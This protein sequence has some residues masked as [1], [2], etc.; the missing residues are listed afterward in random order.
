L[1]WG[2]AAAA[3]NAALWPVAARAATA[4]T[5][6]QPSE[7][8]SNNRVLDTIITAAP[9]RVQLGDHAFPGSLY[10]GAYMPPVLRAR[11]GDTMRI[12]FKNDLPSDPSN[13]HYHGLSVSPQG[14]SDNVFVHVHPG[15]EFKYEV[16]IPANGRQRPGLFWY[17]PHAHGVVAKQMLGGMSG[18]LVIEGSEQ[19]F[20]ILQGL[21]E[22]FFLI[23]HAELGDDNQII[24]ING[25]LDPLVQIRP[26]EMQFWRIAHIGAR[27]SSNWASR[28]CRF[29]SWRPTAI[30]CRARAG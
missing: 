4:E 18:G 30:I 25:Q 26:G 9:G 23:K 27:S 17:H 11:A 13:L 24:S 5:L 20:P 22:R 6:L 19:L 1:R 14:R 8:H 28:A 12:T 10:N 15:Q 2:A 29:M 7:I 3:S 21:P 16:S